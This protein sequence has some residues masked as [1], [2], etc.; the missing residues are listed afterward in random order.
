MP[1]KILHLNFT[2][3]LLI[4]SDSAETMQAF[5]EYFDEN[6]GG[7]EEYIRRHV[8]LSDEDIATIKNNILIP[9]QIL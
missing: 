5:L 8:G 3:C 6:Y 2:G 1:V 7:A 4:I 9:G